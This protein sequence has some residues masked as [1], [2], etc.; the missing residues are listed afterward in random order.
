VKLSLGKRSEDEDVEGMIGI[1]LDD[2]VPGKGMIP[3]PFSLP[4]L[5][6]FKYQKSQTNSLRVFLDKVVKPVN[7]SDSSGSN[8][9]LLNLKEKYEAYCFVNEY[10]EMVIRENK[11]M[12]YKLGFSLST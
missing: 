5:A 12:L 1:I 6:V 8:V 10:A 11:G 4:D 2:E 7:D 9:F 3:A